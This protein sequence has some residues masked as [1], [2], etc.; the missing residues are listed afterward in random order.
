MTSARVCEKQRIEHMLCA[1]R[2]SNMTS[3]VISVVRT[4]DKW[5]FPVHAVSKQKVDRPGNSMVN[6]SVE[7]ELAAVRQKCVDQ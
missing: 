3:T 7:G 6:K 4:C 5:T 1:H 2:S